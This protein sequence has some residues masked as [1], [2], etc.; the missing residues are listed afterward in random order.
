MRIGSRVLAAVFG[1]LGTLAS[2][3]SA[4][5]LQIEVVD[6]TG[7]PVADAVVYA[8][9]ASGKLPA[10]PPE[11]AVIDQIKRQFV[12]LVSVIQTGTSVTFPNKDNFE[13]DV[14]SFSPAKKFE[15]N[16][17][18]GVSAKPVVFDKPGLVVMG[19]NIHDMMI[20]YVLVVDTPYFAMTDASGKAT[21]ENLPAE[22]YRVAAWQY[23]MKD[24]APHPVQ[25][26]TPNPDG[27]AK[28][29]LELLAPP[30]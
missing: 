16:L 29:T 24:G 18:H 15:L 17:Y 6:K 8:T 10:K 1:C 3:A 26:I 11:G 9:P 20:A 4:S 21:I 27:T 5:T 2:Y 23:R 19:C 12:P 22:P 7:A 13:H 25:T 14:Y 28:F 30:A